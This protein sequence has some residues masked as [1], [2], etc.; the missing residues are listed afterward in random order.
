MYV[1]HSSIVRIEVRSGLGKTLACLFQIC[2]FRDFIKSSL[3]LVS[4]RVTWV[5]LNP[6][7]DFISHRTDSMRLRLDSSILTIFTI[8]E[9]Y[10]GFFLNGFADNWVPL[11]FLLRL[12]HRPNPFK[13]CV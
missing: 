10:D 2:H 7:D 12:A 5:G 9:L 8:L 4:R 11:Q 1:D 6:S 3:D 13:E